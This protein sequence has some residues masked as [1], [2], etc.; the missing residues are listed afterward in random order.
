[1]VEWLKKLGEPQYVEGGLEANEGAGEGR[2]LRWGDPES[3]PLYDQ[4]VEIV[5]NRA[6]PRSP[7]YNCAS[8]TTASAASS[9]WNARLV[10]AMQSNGNREVLMPTERFANYLP[11]STQR[12]PLLNSV[13]SVPVVKKV[14]DEILTALVFL[15]SATAHAGSVDSLRAFVRETQTVRAHFAQ[16]CWIAMAAA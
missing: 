11:R 15:V 16:R 9:K 7:A 14:T 12:K 3:D 10:S 6:A 2:V 5:P 13:S 4:A 1:M 8:A